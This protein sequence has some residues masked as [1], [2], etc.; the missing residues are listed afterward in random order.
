MC[1]ELL[2]VTMLGKRVV[3]NINNSH[4]TMHAPIFPMDAMH[5]MHNSIRV[6][7]TENKHSNNTLDSSI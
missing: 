7:I 5:M 4:G 3:T 1:K 2:E 6:S